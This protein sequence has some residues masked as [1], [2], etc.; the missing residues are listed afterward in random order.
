MVPLAVR[1]L[2]WRRVP[3]EWVGQSLHGVFDGGERLESPDHSGSIDIAEV[4]SGNNSIWDCDQHD[5]DELQEQSLVCL[6]ENL[7]M[8]GQDGPRFLRCGRWE[9]CR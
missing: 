1:T 6:A 9:G 4:G 5:V 2:V 3:A 8:V 7:G